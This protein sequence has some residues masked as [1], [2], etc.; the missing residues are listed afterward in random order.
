[1]SAAILHLPRVPRY[2]GP[3]LAEM[4]D[5]VRK[6]ATADGFGV[7]GMEY[8]L[9]RSVPGTWPGA[10]QDLRDLRKHIEELAALHAF[11]VSAAGREAEIRAILDRP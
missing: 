2:E 9:A 1:M 7:N 11:L 4:A 8:M 6:A 3:S 5:T 10:E